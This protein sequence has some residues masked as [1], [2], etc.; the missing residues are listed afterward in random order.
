MFDSKKY[1]DLILPNQCL[2]CHKFLNSSI[3]LCLNCA[4][5][6]RPN[7]SLYC[8]ICH[9]LLLENQMI[10]PIHS[11]NIQAIACLFDWQIPLVQSLIL[12]FKYHN[13]MPLKNLFQ[14]YVES[15][16][17]CHSNI[18][19]EGNFSI[20]PIPLSDE[21]KRMRG[22]NQT[23]IIIPDKNSLKLTIINNNLIRIKNN[24]PQA[25]TVS[26]EDRLENMLNAFKITNKEEISQKNFILIDD[27]YTTGATLNEAAR[28]LKENGAKQ[29][30]G[31]TLA[32]QIY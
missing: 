18:L 14:V 22:F 15:F 3:P 6:L 5:D 1:L 8:P 2:G 20:I 11:P 21:R 32:G 29:I 12:N 10:C 7:G 24:P 17:D 23:E 31:L 30:I 4:K 28:I 9:Q 26:P 25:L 16:L 27:V 19:N 13:L